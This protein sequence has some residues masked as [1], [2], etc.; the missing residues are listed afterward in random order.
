[1]EPGKDDDRTIVLGPPPARDYQPPPLPI[2][3]RD[4]QRY[5]VLGEH[6]R[7]G[8]GR[9]SRAHDRE[10]GRDV[11]IK[12]LL[13][14]GDADELRFLR[15]AL[16]TSRLEHPGIVPVHDAGR[17]AHGTPFYAMKLVAGRPLR[18]L[19]EERARVE[20][21]IGLLHHVIAVADA[22]AYA[23]GRNIIHRDLKPANVVVGEFGETIVIDWGI[24]KDLSSSEEP[25]IEHGP[26]R[27]SSGEDL[28]A[29]GAVLGTPAYMPPEQKRG[30]HVDKR[31]DVFAIG[32]MLWELCAPQRIPP[33]QD[34][35]RRRMLRRAGIDEDLA[36]IIAK[37]LDP[38]PERRYPDAGAL[39]AD[40]KAFKA[41][42]RIAARSYSLFAMLAHWT[43]RHRTLALSAVAAI[44]VAVA[45]SVL[46]IRNI[47]IERDRADASQ[48]SAERA[49]A[50]AEASRASA[51]ASLEELT[52]KHAEL[53]LATDPSAAVDVLASYHGADLARAAQIHAEAAGRG[54][55]LVRALP[56][57]SNVLWTQSIPDGAVLS[58]STD[59]TISR[60]SRDGTS[61]V[62]TRT[63]SRSGVTSYAPSRHLLAYACNPSDVCLFDVLRAAPIP[64]ALPLRN[65]NIRGI[66]LSSDGTLLGVMSRDAVLRVFDVTDPARPAV[67]LTKPIDGGMDVEFTG[68]GVV[69]AWTATGIEFIRMNGT[70]ERYSLPDIGGLTTSTTGHQLAIATTKGEAVILES[71]P[72]RI[73]ARATLCH[74]P[75]N[76]L[77]FIPGRQSIAYACEDG[78]IGTWDVQ[79]GTVRPRGQLEGHADLIAVSTTGEYL[80]AAGGNG[81]V[82]VFDLETDLIAS[83]RGHGV[84]LTSLMPPSPEQPFVVSA[85][86]RGS[87]RVWPLPSRLARVVATSSSP[88]HQAIFDDHSGMVMATTWLPALTTFSPSA[89]VRAVEPHLLHNFGLQR[90]TTGRTF[91]T[92]GLT[93]LVEVWSATTMTRTRVIPTEHGSVT[94]L[95]FVGDTDD[96]ITSGHDG[97]V[98]RWTPTGQQ[99][100]LV[101]VTAPIDRF[102]TARAVGAI[103]F[104]TVDGALW[105]AGADGHAVSLGSGGTRVNLLL[106]LPDQRTVYA[107]YASGAV[108]AID[109]RSWR[110]AIILRGS[111]AVGDIAVTADGRTVAVATNDG[112]VHLGTRHDGA[113]PEAPT[114]VTL[115]GHANHV[116]LAPD[117]LVMAS[118]TDGTI[119]LYAPP[120]RRWICLPTGTVDISQISVTADGRAAV[121][122]DREGRLLW[123]DLEVA[124]KL[125]DT[126]T[127][128][129]NE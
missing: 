21:R 115:A 71:F 83:Y 116:A 82:T 70:S 121:A 72:A 97:R 4:Q 52:L 126:D 75:T 1:M 32:M 15:E 107:G 64:A 35:L 99:T 104:S 53:L 61:T 20:D 44:A 25:S 123:I 125:I 114:W 16:I 11:A 63:V 5:H 120:R 58:L 14:R 48:A 94:Q 87:I 49:R 39:A 81:T 95:Q 79:R 111:G 117:G 91:A 110:Q 122:L 23:H 10:L 22:I 27:A 62:V 74:S 93:D 43:R 102:A 56:H 2:Q 42:A 3:V 100:L 76:D 73:A 118:Y 28:T 59:G 18:E 12:E 127:N 84:R 89:G 8:L 54:V 80:I 34:H 41:G 112:A 55:A 108:V 88:F 67:R 37:A 101:Q 33:D 13:S 86:V 109:T 36:T 105:R 66:A 98:V 38:D 7:G 124:R 96:F 68:D 40:L 113:D 90:S 45:G 9:V 46:Y 129:H 30:E 106:T 128:M 119:W 6:G 31:A 77:R 85:D 24:A 69:V 51:E 78:A 103:V 26:I 47:A 19:I 29:A 50:S 92:Y 57:S 65:A 60:T 17:W